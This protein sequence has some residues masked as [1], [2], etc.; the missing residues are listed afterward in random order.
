M[1]DITVAFHGRRRTK[2]KYWG[3]MGDKNLAGICAKN[4]CSLC[5]TICAKTVASI[6]AKNGCSIGSTICGKN[7]ASICAKNGCSIGNTMG[8]RN[9]GSGNTMRNQHFCGAVVYTAE[10]LQSLAKAFAIMG[11]PMVSGFRKMRKAFHVAADELRR[12]RNV[13]PFLGGCKPLVRAH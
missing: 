6:W 4:G 8:A 3:S 9:V 5:S 1:P 13:S 11:N 10:D 2:G 12:E 7:V